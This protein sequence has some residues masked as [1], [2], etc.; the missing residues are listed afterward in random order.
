MQISNQQVDIVQRS[1]RAKDAAAET[2]VKSVEE[3]AARNGVKMDEVRKFTERALMAEEDPAREKRIRE[4]TR[5][6]AAG[7]YQI[8]AE[9]LVDMAE[10]RAIADRAKDL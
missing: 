6:V 3:L 1:A 2:P 8:E 5:K 7:S 4:L 9:D 10:R